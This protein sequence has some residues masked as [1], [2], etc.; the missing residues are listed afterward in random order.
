MMQR[1]RWAVHFISAEIRWRARLALLQGAFLF[2]PVLSV[3]KT[4]KDVYR[5]GKSMLR[6][7]DGE[8]LWMSGTPLTS[9]EHNS[10]LLQNAL[11]KAVSIKDSRIIVCINPKVLARRLRLAPQT[12]KEYYKSFIAHYWRQ[13]IKVIPKARTYGDACL[14]RFYIENQ[15]LPIKKITKHFEAIKRIWQGKRLL[16]VEGEHTRFGVGNDLV[17]SAR[18]VSRILC[19]DEYCF[20]IIGKIRGAIV[21]RMD[22]YDVCVLVLGPTAT[23]LVGD[24]VG[25]YPTKQFV[26]MGYADSDYMFFVHH[27]IEPCAISHKNVAGI[28]RDDPPSII[29]DFNKKLYEGE[30]VERCCISNGLEPLS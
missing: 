10:P 19:P 30:I 5:Y 20:S 7:G 28:N 27:Q 22:N 16:I 3:S 6:I 17:S 9:F 12:V 8:I 2:T 1:F 26:D 23:V 15:T 13:I 29:F 24:L 25:L 18:I 14:T 11:L 21:N 4:L